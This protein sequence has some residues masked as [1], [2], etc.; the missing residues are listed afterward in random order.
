MSIN[1]I[2]FSHQV[3]DDF[4]RYLFSAFPLTDPDLEKQVRKPLERDAFWLAGRNVS[5]VRDGSGNLSGFSL[6]FARVRGIEF[7]K[8]GTE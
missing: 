6:D 8:A 3:C 5:F 4:L 7:A 2:Q 1:P